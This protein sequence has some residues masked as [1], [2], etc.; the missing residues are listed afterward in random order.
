MDYASTYT[1]FQNVGTTGFTFA[2]I[3]GYDTAH[4][5]AVFGQVGSDYQLSFVA[6]PEPGSAISLLSGLGLL[7]GLRRF[8]RRRIPPGRPRTA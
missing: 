3:I 8:R 1:V 2:D 6:V 5:A 4:Y 7:T